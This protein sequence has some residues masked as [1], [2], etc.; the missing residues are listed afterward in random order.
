MR[1]RPRSARA[2]TEGNNRPSTNTD[3]S[4]W[5]PPTHVH[6]RSGRTKTGAKAKLS[7]RGYQL[8]SR[9]VSG[10]GAMRMR[11]STTTQPSGLRDDGIQIE[12]CHFGQFVD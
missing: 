3:K 12:L 5:A 1:A 4:A 11:A 6:P 10:G 8:L 7:R 2:R 9:V